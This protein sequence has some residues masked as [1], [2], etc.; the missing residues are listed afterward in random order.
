MSVVDSFGAGVAMPVLNGVVVL[1]GVSMV[2]SIG[3][4]ETM[5][6][7]PSCARHSAKG[8]NGRLREGVLGTSAR[9]P[10]QSGAVRTQAGGSGQA[11]RNETNAGCD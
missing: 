11:K 1:L 9:R 5:L 10:E 2:D 7:R 4:G 6:Q 8:R 3:A